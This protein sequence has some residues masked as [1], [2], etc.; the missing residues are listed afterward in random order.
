MGERHQFWFT[1]WT[2]LQRPNPVLSALSRRQELSTLWFPTWSV[3]TWSVATCS[4]TLFVFSLRPRPDCQK[5]LKMDTSSSMQLTHRLSY[6][7]NY[8][9]PRRPCSVRKG[10]SIGFLSTH[11]L[12]KDGQ[13]RDLN[14]KTGSLGEVIISLT[15]VIFLGTG[16]HVYSSSLPR[17]TI[18]L[19]SSVP[20]S[21]SCRLDRSIA[22]ATTD[23]CTDHQDLGSVI[24]A[25]LMVVLEINRCWKI[26]IIRML[27]CWHIMIKS[28]IDDF[29]EQW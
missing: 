18:A 29:E 25:T 13:G 11:V 26:I 17:L 23:V 1:F 10:S 27:I 20:P 4:D 6:D 14:T 21:P 16:F 15:K 28:I 2:K 7:W 5:S 24:L 8:S 22:R 9:S 3:A 19:C 12:R